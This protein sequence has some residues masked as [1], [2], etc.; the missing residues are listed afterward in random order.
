MLRNTK[1][2][3]SNDIAKLRHEAQIK[4]ILTPNKKDTDTPRTIRPIA[5]LSSTFKVY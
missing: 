2:V 1:L 3:N 5:L 4:A